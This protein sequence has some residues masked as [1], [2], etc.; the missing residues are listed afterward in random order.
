MIGINARELVKGTAGMLVLRTLSGEALHGYA[1]I[2]KLRE[3][4]GG[5]F[6]IKEG[7]LYPILHALE[8]EGMVEAAWQGEGRRKRVYRISVDGQKRLAAL[9]GEW[10]RAKRGVDLVLGGAQYA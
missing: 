6:D 8:A 1:L 9:Q 3:K 5:L 2:Q 7:T 4:S 10:E